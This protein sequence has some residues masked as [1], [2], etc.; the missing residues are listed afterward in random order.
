M[1]I[2]ASGGAPAKKL[3]IHIFLQLQNA[4]SPRKKAPRAATSLVINRIAE[5]THCRIGTRW[6]RFGR[7]GGPAQFS[8]A[9]SSYLFSCIYAP[10]SHISY[11]YAFGFAIYYADN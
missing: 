7:C 10:G 5:S 8:F 1:H 6:R 4:R 2:V 11:M 3:A 9:L